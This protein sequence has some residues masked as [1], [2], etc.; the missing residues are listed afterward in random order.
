MGLFTKECPFCHHTVFRP[1][2]W[3]HERRHTKLLDDGQMTDHYELREEDRYKGSLEGVPQVY[4]HEKCGAQT[5]MPEDIIRS[6]LVKPDLYS[7]YTFCVG[8]NDYVPHS[9]VSWVETGESLMFI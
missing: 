2:Y 9:E 3:L 6:Y 7:P 1:L 5:G 4:H 8:C